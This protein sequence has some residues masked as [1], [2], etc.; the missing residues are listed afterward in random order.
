MTLRRSLAALLV[1]LLTACGGPAASTRGREGDTFEEDVRLARV[2][3][4]AFWKAQFEALGR[5]YEPVTDFVAYDD[6]FRPDAHGTAAQRQRSFAT[7][8]NNGVGAC[9]PQG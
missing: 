1:L 8:Y 6:W 7:G 9:T 4:E 5:T 3:T 2:H